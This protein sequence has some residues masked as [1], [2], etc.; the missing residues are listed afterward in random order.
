MDAPATAVA[1][2]RAAVRAAGDRI[3]AGCL[4]TAEAARD[5]L[6]W[7]ADPRNAAKVS[8]DRAAMAGKLRRVASEAGRLARSATRPTCVG[9]FG[10]SQAGKSYLISILARQG[11]KPLVAAFD[12]ERASEPLH[13]DFIEDIN[14]MGGDEST[15]VVT[16]F[17]IHK[18][19]S[20]AGYPVCLKLLSQTDIVKILVNSYF[21]DGDQ[22][23]E[24]VTDA[25]TLEGLLATA[26]ARARPAPTDTLIAADVWDLQDYL[27]RNSGGAATA[28][29]PGPFWERIAAVAPRLD[30]PARAELLSVLWG[31]HET[32]TKIYLRLAEALAKLRFAADAFVRTDAL[33]PS[34]DSVI[35]VNALDGIHD[36]DARALDVATADGTVASLPRPL[37]TA[38]VAELRIVCRDKPQP[39]FEHTDLLDFPGYRTRF[40]KDLRKYFR[41][42]ADT[43]SKDVFL[44]GKVDYLFQRY[45]GELELTTM[46]LCVPD[47][48][49]EVASLP[50]AIETWV[51]LTHGVSPEKRL[52]K[53]NLLFLALTKF[54][55]TLELKAGD[56]RDMFGE[57]LGIRFSASMNPFSKV[58]PSWV[59][60]WW[61]RQP[62]RNV[63]LVRNPTVQFRGVIEYDGKH[64]V[65]I[66]PG[67]DGRLADLRAAFVSLPVAAEHF[68]DPGSAWDALMTLND[69]GAGRL[70]AELSR[71]CVADLKLGQIA[72]RLGEIRRDV[73][74]TLARYH[75]SDDWATRR[76]ERLAFVDQVLFADLNECAERAR[77]GSA[78]R[79]L[80]IDASDLHAALTET[81]NRTGVEGL[82]EDARDA[83]LAAPPRR[84]GPFG[85]RKAAPA[86]TQ[87]DAPASG[88]RPDRWSRL[89]DAALARWAGFLQMRTEDAVFARRIGIG[90]ASLREMTAEIGAAARRLKLA[91]RVAAELR[92]RAGPNEQNEAIARKAAL[93]AEGLINRFVSELDFDRVSPAQQIE[94]FREDLDEPV[95]APRP[96]AFDASG[97]GAD[98]AE[99]TNRFMEQWGRAFRTTVSHNAVAQTGTLEEAEQN[100]RLGKILVALAA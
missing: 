2:D 70:A 31:R 85:A 1:G 62:F 59:R 74:D 71:V 37:V 17:T 21:Q 44:R 43:A 19:P 32:Y 46:V 81:L 93:V 55:R 78:L 86:A 97:I 75:V 28:S 29:G 99:F 41:E 30:L 94:R 42:A 58:E 33:V 88:P 53:P 4:A 10:P 67:E 40:K 56:R 89:A 83:T 90:A 52:G 91:E 92:L 72:A 9:V 77:F 51:G 87:I 54:D 39:F 60:Q 25:A 8:Q 35:N 47:S 49:M 98:P 64:E 11:S 50:K 100:T 18:L 63:F 61:P 13:I 36:A 24:S 6:A 22:E 79:G 68:A 80:M 76:A 5:A 69:G 82:A 27:A 84:V 45:T 16:R 66:V 12:G 73:L 38:L 14:P 26:E 15:G 3:A 23:Y 65:R 20:P 34:R 48:V 57:K 7:I 96:V 95:F